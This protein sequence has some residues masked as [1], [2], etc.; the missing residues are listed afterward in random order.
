MNRK[1]FFKLL[2]LGALGTTSAS[3][4]AALQRL[5][6]LL[7]PTDPL[8]V[9]FFGHGSPMNAVE[10]N[11]FVEGWRALAQRLDVQP[12]AVLCIS[13]HWETVG[14]RITAMPQPRTIHD[15]GGF[16]AELYAIQYPAP[17]HP[18][19]AAHIAGGLPGQVALDEEWG[20][21]HG[22]WSVLKH[23]FPQADVPV[24]Q[25][26][27]DRR[28]D[29]AAH[30]ALAQQLTDLRRRG[31]LVVG[32][33]NLVHNL[34]QIAWQHLNDVGYA[35]HWAATAHAQLNGWILSG[36][37]GA[38]IA[39]PTRSDH[40]LRLAIP[41]A[42]HYLP[43]LY[44]LG[45]QQPGESLELFNDHAVGGSITMTSVAIGLSA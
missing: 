45:M 13:A 41:T 44:V 6:A 40:A 36:D 33:G 34:G 22:T 38:L 20:L 5:G 26:S 4:G 21:D 28:M 12:Q 16:P 43:L 8:P 31:V 17:G 9:L 2:G 14:T 19:L 42:E 15:F 23:I 37:H 27:L 35:H 11:R 32:S 1:D 24:L 10:E 30:Y 39:A 18:G 25:L 3:W 29:A 7:P